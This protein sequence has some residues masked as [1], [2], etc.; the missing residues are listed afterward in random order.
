MVHPLDFPNSPK[1]TKIQNPQNPKSKI[2]NIQNPKS[3]KSKFQNPRNPKF[4]QSKIQNPPNPNSK[5]QNP[6]N[7]QFGDFGFWILDF[8]SLCSN[9]LCEAT[10]A[11]NFGFW[12]KILDVGFWAFWILDLGDFGFWILDFGDFGSWGFWILDF[13]ALGI[14]DFGFWGRNPKSKIQNPNFFGRFWGFWILD[15]YVANLFVAANFGDFGFWG[16]WILDFGSWGFWILGILDFGFWGFGILDCGDFGSWILDRYV[17]NLY[18][19][20]PTPGFRGFW[21]LDFEVGGMKKFGCKIR[22]KFWILHKSKNTVH[23]APGR[24]INISK[25][26]KKI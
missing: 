6:Q 22:S 26:E 5:I 4:P 8:G 10:N 18:V 20:P 25:V 16:F 11:P 14:L 15:R 2:P 24:R 9:S 3:L 12:R 17:A 21:I 1:I 23:A 13:G 19:R 7:P